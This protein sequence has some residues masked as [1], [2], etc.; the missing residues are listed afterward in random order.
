VPAPDAD[1]VPIA[2]TVRPPSPLAEEIPQSA[3]ASAEEQDP[4][5]SEKN[6]TRVLEA[7]DPEHP[8]GKTGLDSFERR[9]AP[10]YQYA[11]TEAPASQADGLLGRAESNAT[12]EAADDPEHPEGNA[13][14]QELEQTS[15]MSWCPPHTDQW[16]LKCTFARCSG[17]AECVAEGR[18]VR[19]PPAADLEI[20][21]DPAATK[22]LPTT[23]DDTRELHR[24][25]HT[26]TRMWRK[27]DDKI[28]CCEREMLF[29]DNNT[30][31]HG[32]FS[33]CGGIP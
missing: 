4:E 17:C 21:D 9:A 30:L 25:K 12:S 8:E 14:L 5:H 33:V 20:G 28:M 16:E 15:C 19:Q 18:R 7:A 23:T 24:R 31:L 26:T 1:E 13:T 3:E 29:A 10:D 22:G 6:V 11:T 2:W 32:C 27:I